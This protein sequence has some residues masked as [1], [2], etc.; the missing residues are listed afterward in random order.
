MKHRWMALLTGVAMAFAMSPGWAANVKDINYASKAN[1]LLGGGQYYIYHVRCSDGK[2]K[3]ISGW[4]NRKK[5]CLGK[6]KK[7]CSNDQLQTAKQ[8]CQ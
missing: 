4:D 2:K 5:W 3:V 7:K 1:A 8:A 6:S